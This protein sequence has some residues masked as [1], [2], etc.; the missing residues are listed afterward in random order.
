MA[1]SSPA[2]RRAELVRFVSLADDPDSID[3][4]RLRDASFGDETDH[5]LTPRAGALPRLRHGVYFPWR[6]TYHLV[7]NRRWE[8]KHSGSGK[9]FR[10]EARDVFPRTVAFI[11]A[12]A[13]HG[14]RPRV[15][16]R[17]RRQRPRPRSTATASPGGSSGWRSRSPFSPRGD[18]R[19]YLVDPEGGSR[20]VV[21]APIYWFNDMDY[22]GVLPDPFFSYSVRVDG[23]FD[24]A[25]VRALER[26]HRR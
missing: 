8:D 10:E 20:T 16:L 25:W 3:P 12:P 4:D 7:E 22:H 9:D 1:T 19:F 24:R 17:P 5:P 11:E 14:D 6:H 15:D 13:L 23:V 18:K 26:K 2:S 21:R